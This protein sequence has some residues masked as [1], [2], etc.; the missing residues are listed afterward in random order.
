ML[1]AKKH[2]LRVGASNVLFLVYLY[3]YTRLWLATPGLT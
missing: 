1:Q 2:V 3:S